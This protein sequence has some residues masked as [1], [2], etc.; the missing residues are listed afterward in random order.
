VDST[1]R[2]DSKET[3]AIWQVWQATAALEQAAYDNAAEARQSAAE[4]LQLVP[5][6]QGVEVEAALAFAMAGDTVRAE[7]LATRVGE[8]LPAR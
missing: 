1:V 5:T 7:S 6:S 8:T 2:A 3:G 4:A